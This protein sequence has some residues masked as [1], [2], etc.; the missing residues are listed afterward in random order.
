VNNLAYDTVRLPRIQKAVE[1]LQERLFA[2]QDSTDGAIQTTHS[3]RGGAVPDSRIIDGALRGRYGE[4]FDRIWRGVSGGNLSEDDFFLA[5]EVVHQALNLGYRDDELADVVERTMR[6]SAAYRPKWDTPRSGTAD[7]TSIRTT[8]LGITIGKAISK[9]ASRREG[10]TR[11]KRSGQPVDE[12]G[13]TSSRPSEEADGHPERDGGY[14]HERLAAQRSVIAA[15]QR[16]AAALK[17]RLGGIATLIGVPGHRLSPSAKLLGLVLAD[18]IERTR[19]FG[20]DWVEVRYAD[21]AAK[22]G[23]SVPTVEREMKTLCTDKKSPHVNPNAPFWKQ[24]V[25]EMREVDG[26]MRPISATSISAKSAAPVLAA[27]AAYTPSG[28]R[29]HGGRR[30]ARPDTAP[31]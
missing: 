31:N 10:V 12:D 13:T 11:S 27:I 17:E 14:L 22:A 7:G 16:E 19:P 6:A 5:S 29:Q 2:G 15:H 28:P 24:T 21:L 8:Y 1:S 26:T 3:G 9:Q 25:T 23:L 18:I 4:K 30:E 20:R